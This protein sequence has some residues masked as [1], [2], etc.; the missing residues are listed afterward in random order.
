MRE[1]CAGSGADTYML[2]DAASGENPGDMRILVS[3]WT[4]DAIQSVGIDAI[5]YIGESSASA[6]V[7]TTPRSWHP[8]ALAMLLDREEIAGL[9]AFGHEEIVALRLLVAGRR[10]HLLLSSIRH[11]ALDCAAIATQH[12][13]CFY[14]LAEFEGSEPEGENPLS[15]RERECLSWVSHGKTTDEIA[16]ILDV[17]PSTIN[18]YIAHAIHKLAARNRAMAIACA[19]RRNLI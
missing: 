5:R 16:L 19:I 12:V 9:A 13:R 15:E 4:Y 14:A 18:C 17:S 8:M 6:Y 1:L 10:H 2:L 11:D 7:G 3:N